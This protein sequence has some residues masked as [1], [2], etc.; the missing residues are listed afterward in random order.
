MAIPGSVKD[1]EYQ[2]FGEDVEGNV[3]RFVI[4]E[5]AHDL[6]A[7]ISGTGN[8]TPHVF[9]VAV[10][11]ADT[12]YSQALP[13]NT[14]AFFLKCRT[15][16]RM[17]LAYAN[18]ESGTKFVTIP[19]GGFWVDQNFYSAQTVYFQSVKAGVTVEIVAFV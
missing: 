11:S 19:P 1:R 8:T 6:L 2:N 18:G 12:E 3:A 15:V 4:D 5:K 16:S 17:K 14:K 10:A 9:N 7:A 13:N